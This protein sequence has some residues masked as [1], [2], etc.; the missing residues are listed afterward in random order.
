[1]ST[2]VT[3]EDATL[4]VHRGASATPGGEAVP[5]SPQPKKMP[6]VP[7]LDGVRA[8]AI[9][10]V[11][12]AHSGLQKLIPGGLGVTVFFFLSGFLI[13]SLMRSEYARTGRVSFSGFYLRRTLRIMPPLYI[14]LAVSAVAVYSGFLAWRPDPLAI[15][16]QA[17]FLI[18]YAPLWGHDQGLP[19]PPLWSL[20]VEEHFYLIFPFVYARFLAA[21]PASRAARWC[22]AICLGVLAIRVISALTLADYS[23]NY[24]FTHTRIDSI[25]WGSCLALWQNPVL[26]D[27]AWRPKPWHIAAAVATML[28]SLAFRDHFFRETLRY[29]LQ[30]MAIFVLMSAALHDK[31][32]VRAVLGSAPA[33][34]IGLLSYTLYLCHLG[35]FMV[36]DQYLP[37]VQGAPRLALAGAMSMAFA[38]LMYVAVERP[39]ARIRKR[40]HKAE[41]RIDAETKP[42]PA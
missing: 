27:D 26:D 14:T 22:A 23:S 24:F 29:T 35:M 11:F 30:G 42:V 9:L 1:V 36:L 28:L 37:H 13:T 10:L 41:G 16:A 8:L 18:N 3:A 38:G 19:G 31:G 33:R 39:L 25:L 6:H 7:Q 40:S 15:L 12:F 34:L 20:A 32:S 2:H 21:M 17:G 5:V 4:D